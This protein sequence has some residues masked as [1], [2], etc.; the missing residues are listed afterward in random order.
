L[1]WLVPNGGAPFLAWLTVL[2]APL[3]YAGAFVGDAEVHLVFGRNAAA[4]NFYQFNPDEVSAGETSAGWM[5]I[6]AALFRALPEATVPHAAKL[7]GVCA[8]YL[9]L[10]LVWQWLRHR[11]VS[12]TVTIAALLV[13]GL[14]PGSVFSAATGMENGLFG[15][16]WLPASAQA[17]MALTR[18]EG[19]TLGPF[20]F[21]PRPL[22][23]LLA[24]APV[25]ALGLA[26]VVR[27]WRDRP[28]REEAQALVAL[29]AGALTALLTL[30]TGSL[31]TSRYLLPV[32]LLLT[33][34]AA[35]EAERWLLRRPEMPALRTA[36]GLAV[37]WLLGVAG[38][39]TAARVQLP[40]HTK[41]SKLWQAPEQRRERTDRLLQQ[42]DRRGAQ[43][44]V[45]GLREVQLRYYLDERVTV[46]GIDGRT[47]RAFLDYV[48]DGCVDQA[49]W[50]ADS[51]IEYLLE[52]PNV[53]AVCSAWALP[54]LQRLAPGEE[55]QVRAD[56]RIRR[57]AGRSVFKLIR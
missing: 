24:Y 52:T 21:D 50:L 9:S 42:L 35:V 56:L 11:G 43:R 31:H 44:V 10:L 16:L 4:G 5:L 51:D 15:L 57:L 14:L 45:V 3:L 2:A 25:T 28:A 18:A 20:F 1:R 26:A 36:A 7:I 40:D 23:R 49:A 22:L 54:R 38:V 27:L 30:V 34:L 32:N 37:V 6:C 19:W 41:L 29:W 53:G 17:R 48:S 8:W 39:E 13:A 47:D 55:V 33:M 12:M 46:R